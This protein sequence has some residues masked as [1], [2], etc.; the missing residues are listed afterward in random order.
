M[1]FNKIFDAFPAPEI[2]DI[3]F[4][5]LSLTDSAIRCIQFGKKD[6]GLYVQKYTEKKLNSGVIVSGQINDKEGLIR[7]LQTIKN[8][9]K[10]EYVRVSLPEEKAYLFTAKIPIVKPN[11]V[12]S[13][14]ESKIEE[15][16]PVN[17]V[18]LLYDY[19]LIDHRDR[20][21]LD[22]VVSNVPISIIDTYMDVISSAGLNLLS[23]E[24]ESQAVARALIDKD[25]HGTVLIVHFGPQKVGLYVANDKIVRFT[26]TMPIK[27]SP[28]D[29]LEFLSHEIKKLFVYWHTLKENV[30]RSEKKINEI[31]ISGEISGEDVVRYLSK[32]NTIPVVLGDV[33]TNTFDID[34]V[35]P[36]INFSDS[37]RYAVSVGLALPSDFL[38]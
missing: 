15:N 35:V 22:V 7:A 2:L 1:K 13:A 14:I 17:P 30:D 23:L 21:H 11:E 37:L 38:I 16:V 12:V 33:W 5:G 19:K 34:E 8:D 20:G 24:I 36:E 25:N 6:G 29:N 32:E 4:A 18:E 27:G 10:L 9:L 3:P 31:L 28:S 26:S